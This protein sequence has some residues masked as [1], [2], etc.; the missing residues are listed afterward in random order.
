MTPDVTLDDIKAVFGDSITGIDNKVN[1]ANTKLQSIGKI[2]DIIGDKVNGLESYQQAIVS[3]IAELS[4]YINELKKKETSNTNP[5]LQVNSTTTVP[6]QQEAPK[7]PTRDRASSLEAIK[8]IPMSLANVPQSIKVLPVR[9]LEPANSKKNKEQKFDNLFNDNTHLQPFH[10]DIIDINIPQ[11]TK[12]LLEDILYDTF[13]PFHDEELKV[14]KDTLDTVQEILKLLIGNNMILGGNAGKGGKGT[15]PPKGHN[16]PLEI[17][18]ILGGGAA[19]KGISRI[20]KD[21][22]KKIFGEKTP[23]EMTEPSEVKSVENVKPKTETEEVLN[24]VKENIKTKEE[25]ISKNLTETENELKRIDGERE[26][27]NKETTEFQKKNA[28]EIQKL[29]EE[30]TELKAKEVEAARD[31]QRYTE[32]YQKARG[33][34]EQARIKYEETLKESNIEAQTQA[35]REVDRLKLTEKVLKNQSEA[36]ERIG[37]E[38]VAKEKQIDVLKQQR[39]DADTDINKK[40]NELDAKRIELANKQNTLIEQ[41][42][43]KIE[44]T[45]AKETLPS[46]STTP[47]TEPVKNIEPIKQPSSDSNISGTNAGKA[48]TAVEEASSFSKIVKMGGKLLKG[49]E[50]A[51]AGLQIYEDLK[52]NIEAFANHPELTDEQQQKIGSISAGIGTPANF[53]IGIGDLTMG[54]LQGLS[55]ASDEAELKREGLSTDNK[56]WWESFK[57]GYKENIVRKEITNKLPE[58]SVNAAI[59]EYLIKE[60]DKNQP[61]T[62]D[63]PAIMAPDEQP[64]PVY[65]LAPVDHPVVPADIKQPATDTATDESQKLLQIQNNLLKFYLE[66]SKQTALNTGSLIDAFKDFKENTGSKIQLNNISSPTSFISN[67]VT[68]TAF[69][70]NAL[71]GR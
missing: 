11:E 56:S 6:L 46:A 17:L 12:V 70:Q 42:N 59:R 27:L 52:S 32:E 3:K 44:P 33:Q 69:R 49:L 2:Q 41:Q 64:V 37:G 10:H 43:A 1:N 71:Q 26:S 51:A 18:E 50:I 35:S 15:P 22:Y 16:W 21:I 28:A 29:E 53:L 7:Q 62:S 25:E 57:Q 45:V 14:E 39:L 23:K 47:G 63:K 9:I 20:I 55:R 4:K 66:F 13:R 24:K 61:N 8:L 40:L 68:S 5:Y 48:A 65:N 34:T 31:T 30:I 19:I 38:I 36:E 60:E 58:G 54:V 67:P